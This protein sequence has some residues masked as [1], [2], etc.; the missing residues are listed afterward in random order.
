MS[1][2][3]PRLGRL[4]NDIKNCR[5]IQLSAGVLKGPVRDAFKRGEFDNQFIGDFHWKC[6]VTILGDASIANR[7]VLAKT[8]GIISLFASGMLE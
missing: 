3:Q 2:S 8:W 7:L 6:L 4:K 5:I 1:C